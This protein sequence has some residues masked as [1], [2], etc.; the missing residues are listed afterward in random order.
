MISIVIVIAGLVAAK[1]P[2]DRAV[3]GHRAADGHDH[4]ELSG[5]ERRDA[6]ETVA[7]PIEE[8][9]SGVEN[10]LYFS[11]SSASTAR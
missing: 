7:A 3:P 6:R 9:L 2:A 11:S 4:R 1:H 8:Q 10:M 5:R